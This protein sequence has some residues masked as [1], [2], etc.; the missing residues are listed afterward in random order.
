MRWKMMD[1]EMLTPKTLRAMKAC[2]DP[3]IDSQTF[4]TDVLLAYQHGPTYASE[5]CG[6]PAGV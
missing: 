3:C 4:E 5:T 6:C 1:L 2:E